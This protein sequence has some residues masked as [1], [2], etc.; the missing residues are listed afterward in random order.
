MKT[1]RRQGKHPVSVGDRVSVAKTDWERG[2]TATLVRFVT[3]HSGQ[4]VAVVTPRTHRGDI[5]CGVRHV[6]PDRLTKRH[7]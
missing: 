2:W 4:L 1:L 5:G 7:R 6:D 3:D